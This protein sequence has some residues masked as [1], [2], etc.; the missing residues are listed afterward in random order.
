M[1]TYQRWCLLSIFAAFGLACS[2]AGPL[3]RPDANPAEAR[4]NLASALDAWKAGAVTALSTKTPPV[5][6]A[7][8]DLA[9]GLKLVDYAIAEPA[10]DSE[11]VVALNLVDQ[12][13]RSVQRSATYQVTT[14]EKAAVLRADP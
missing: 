14:G 10:S 13:G 4:A 1:N 9:D 6:F 5:R 3:A 12:S 8:D 2:N 11:F 7:D